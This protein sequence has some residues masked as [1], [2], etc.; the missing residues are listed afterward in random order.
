MKVS[1]G[2]GKAVIGV[3]DTYA[4]NSGAGVFSYYKD[5]G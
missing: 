1:A 4:E 5:V 3:E 2:G